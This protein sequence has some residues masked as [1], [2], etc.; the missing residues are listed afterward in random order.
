MNFKNV[1][2]KLKETVKEVTPKQA[3]ELQ[4]KGYILLDI[5]EPHEVSQGTPTGA[6]RINRSHLEARVL[7]T[8]PDLEQ[9]IMTMCASGERSLFV[10]QSLMQLGYRHVS[11]VSGGF[12][13]WK[14][15]SLPFEMPEALTQNDRER[16][17][18]QITMPEIKEKGQLKLS[19]AKVLCIGAGGLGSPIAMYLAAGGI[20]TIGIIDDDIVDRSNLQRQIIHTDERIGMTKTDSAE[21]T[22]KALNPTVNVKK[23]NSRLTSD[24]IEEVFSGYDVIVDG[25]DNFATR[26]LVNDACVKLKLPNV[27]GSV[28]RFEGQVTV[29]WP[30]YSKHR[31][32]CYRCLYLEPPPPELAPSCADAGVLGILPGTIGLLEAT[33]TIKII[34]DLGDLLV[35][36]L[37]H[38]DALKQRFVELKC[39]RN[40]DCLYCGDNRE[41]PGYVD[42]QKFCRSSS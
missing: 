32:P 28:F 37:L 38:Y 35:G 7:Q 8:F 21:F 4:Q 31:G 12:V 14:N 33:E 16:Y 26:Y 24:N 3:Y 22:L 6:T 20:G 9:P 39:Q 29:F 2:K 1:L 40:P 42:Y 13:Q 36:R 41:F 17:A 5:R 10:A 27:H 25:S 18:R 15:E 11:S 23:Y 30:A 34:L 19:N